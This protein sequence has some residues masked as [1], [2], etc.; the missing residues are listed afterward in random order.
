M[1]SSVPHQR[2]G[3]EGGGRGEERGAGKVER[4][5]RVWESCF[6]LKKFRS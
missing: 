6:A 4:R 1:T 2:L 3:D 5:R